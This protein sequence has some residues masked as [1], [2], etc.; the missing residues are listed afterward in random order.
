[1]NRKNRQKNNAGVTL[2]ELVVVISIITILAAI[3]IPQ[4]GRFIA[5]SKVRQVATD[6]LQNIRLARTMAIKEQRPYVINFNG[7]A[8]SYSIGFD[9]NDDGTPE[10][11]GI[12]GTKV[13]NIQNQYSNSVVL[14][15]ANFT[16]VPPNGP[17]GAAINDAVSF[18]FDLDGSVDQTGIVYLQ[19]NIRGYAY[20]IEV[21]NT[22]GKMDL[23][24]WQGDADNPG[25]PGWVELR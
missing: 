7:G 14:T 13:F 2:I 25:D 3:G 17:N 23:Y 15:A 4:Y 9:T 11:Y 16:T 22:T 5:R 12:T 24:V 18:T 6:M 1:M 19:Q 10:G 8:N 20:C 21:V